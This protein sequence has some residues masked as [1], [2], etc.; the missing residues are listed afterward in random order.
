MQHHDRGGVVRWRLQQPRLLLFNLVCP[1]VAAENKAQAFIM[2]SCL[3]SFQAALLFKDA[4]ASHTNF[5]NT[6]TSFP[7]A[8]PL[9]EAVSGSSLTKCQTHVAA[10]SFLMSHEVAAGRRRKEEGR[11]DGGERTEKNRGGKKGL[12]LGAFGPAFNCRSCPTVSSLC[13]VITFDPAPPPAD[14]NQCTL[15]AGRSQGPWRGNTK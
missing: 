11:G 4:L 1:E 5:K 8:R 6:K 9:A 10:I 14:N 15:Q 7:A 2:R 13:P 3:C 12:N